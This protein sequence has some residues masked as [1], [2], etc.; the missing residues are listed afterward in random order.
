MKIGKFSKR[1][2]SGSLPNLKFS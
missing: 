2:T 1:A